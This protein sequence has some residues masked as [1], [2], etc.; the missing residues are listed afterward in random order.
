MVRTCFV[1]DFDWILT[2]KL[3]SA[4]ASVIIPCWNEQSWKINI[5][6]TNTF[7]IGTF[8]NW[9]RK[10]E[11]WIRV[12]Q[13]HNQNS[14]SSPLPQGLYS[15]WT[16]IYLRFLLA[17]I[18]LNEWHCPII[19]SETGEAHIDSFNWH[20]SYESKN[21][22]SSSSVMKKL[23]HVLFVVQFNSAFW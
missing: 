10:Y 6:R 9:A 21:G 15:S 1:L 23:C 18:K 11:Y 12:W 19:W 22:D 5:K 4:L 13:L 14:C 2:W 20:S 3:P 8:W 17:F 16:R 7:I